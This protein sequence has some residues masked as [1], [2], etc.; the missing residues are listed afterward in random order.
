MQTENELAERVR[1]A[2]IEAALQAYEDGGI[3]GLCADGRWELAIQ[4]MRGLDL[5]ALPDPYRAAGHQAE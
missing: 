4:A 5:G 1:Q 2:C 3:S